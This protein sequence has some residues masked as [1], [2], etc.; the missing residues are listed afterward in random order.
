M[1]GFFAKRG[2]DAVIVNA[3][4]LEFA[5]GRLSHRGKSI[6]MVYNRVTDF[7]FDEDVHTALRRAYESGAAVITPH[8]RAHALLADK[9]NLARLTDGGFLR[10]IGASQSD[11]E[12]LQSG[13]PQ[14]RLVVDDEEWWRDRKQWFFKPAAGFGSRG[15]Y[16]G[17]KLTRR[18]FG[19]VV[20]GGYVA[21]RMAVPGQRR[22]APA[23]G[24]EQFKVDLRHY[25]Y[26]GRTQLLAARLYQGQTTNFR[27]QGGGFAPVLELA[28]DAASRNVWRDCLPSVNA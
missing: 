11:I 6:D 19:E 10:S 5:D 22:R 7:Y 4:D 2:I 21:Q 25:V 8:P 23:S 16:R 27:T 17:D 13:I 9:R 3:A 12:V 1:R 15:A 18:V 14:S 20:K 28:D 24:P 26:D